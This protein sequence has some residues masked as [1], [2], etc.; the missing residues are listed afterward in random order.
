MIIYYDNLNEGVVLKRTKEIIT[1]ERSR[2][3]RPSNSWEVDHSECACGLSKIGTD[4]LNNFAEVKLT[5]KKLQMLKVNT[6]TSFSYMGT[7]CV[8]ISVTPQVA[9]CPFIIF[10]CLFSGNC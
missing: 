4:I 9:F 5:C 7:Y 10:L 6:W 2:L 3:D 1:R 8:K